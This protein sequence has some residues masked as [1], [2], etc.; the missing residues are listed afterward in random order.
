M[1]Y[2]YGMAF[3]VSVNFVKFGRYEGKIL[4]KESFFIFLFS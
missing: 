3:F 1:A 4:K 2:K